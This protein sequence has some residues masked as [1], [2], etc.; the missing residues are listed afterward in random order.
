[1]VPFLLALLHH[2]GSGCARR[3]WCPARPALRA[4]RVLVMG[5]R[6]GA[7]ASDDDDDV[8]EKEKWSFEGG[9]DVSAFLAG[10][11]KAGGN[12]DKFI[13]AER[14]PAAPRRRARPPR[15]ASEAPPTRPGGDQSDLAEAVARA[16]AQH[17]LLDPR[18]EPLQIVGAGELAA[19]VRAAGIAR[20]SR[21]LS[22]GA[23]SALR[24][25]VLAEVERSEAEVASGAASERERFSAVL[26]GRASMH[27]ARTRWDVRLPL[28]PPVVAAV[29]E[30][31]GGADA[32]LAFAFG[33]LAGGGRAE[34]WELAAVVSAPGAAAQL[35]HADTLFS[36]EPCLFTAFVALQPVTRE[37]GPTCFVPA[38]HAREADAAMRRPDREGRGAGAGAEFLAQAA[39][40][41]GCMDVGDATL[42]DGRLLHAGGPNRSKEHRVLLY[43]TFRH[44][45]ANALELGNEAAHSIRPELAARRATL[46][47][48]RRGTGLLASEAEASRVKAV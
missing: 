34:L 24:A 43:L 5:A 40:R 28:A 47:K 12:I 45:G 3:A 1:M 32:P 4:G 18:A 6:P 16:G 39:P 21:V 48:L 15:G 2:A 11:E 22:K 14:G 31:L 19:T 37:M 29:D 27:S 13:E 23:A 20:A 25:F 42:Y 9:L 7:D 30:L 17:D 44:V 8:G 46:A 38:S 36:P 26:S 10:L 33:R 41:L 35:V